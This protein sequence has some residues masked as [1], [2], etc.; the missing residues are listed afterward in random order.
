MARGGARPGAGRKP[1]G[2]GVTNT[3]RPAK[4][5]IY[6]S[7][8]REAESKIKDRLP[9][10]VD[11]MLELAD[12]VWEEKQIGDAAV[13]VYKNRPDRQAISDL[14]DRI[15]GKAVQPISLVDKV[16]EMAAAEGLTDEETEAAVAEAQQIVRA[17]RR[18]RS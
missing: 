6:E 8:I 9:W 1:G 18:A 7:P 15:M 17:P 14:L 10:L 12:G 5:R 4:R 2:G 11:K 16:R 13:I 3:G